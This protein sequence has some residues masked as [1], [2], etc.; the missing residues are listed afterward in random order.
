MTYLI[1]AG[2][3]WL[4]YRLRKFM[5]LVVRTRQCTFCGR[6]DTGL[7][8]TKF[9]TTTQELYRCHACGIGQMRT[10]EEA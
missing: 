2:R 9:W 5:R 10:V 4:V 3:E 1:P 7:S 6:R 8:D